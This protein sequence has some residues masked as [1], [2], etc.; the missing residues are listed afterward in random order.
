M[1]EKDRLS[2]T[3]A[4][5]RPCAS[6][7]TAWNP[8]QCEQVAVACFNRVR[9]GP[10]TMAYCD[11]RRSQIRVGIVRNGNGPR[12][13]P[14]ERIPERRILLVGANRRQSVAQKRRRNVHRSERWFPDAL[15]WSSGGVQ[16]VLSR[17]RRRHQLVDDVIEDA[18]T[19]RC[20]CCRQ[21]RRCLNCAAAEKKC[22][23]SGHRR[24]AGVGQGHG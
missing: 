24:A 14:G 16:I 9:L 17:G 18:F 3:L 11:F 20:C 15:L 8:M 6:Y 7:P 21:S 10:V 2:R 22:K 1:L 12:F 23:P 4:P 5:A 19:C 13:Q